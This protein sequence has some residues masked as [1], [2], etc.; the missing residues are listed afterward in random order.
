MKP[1]Q[2]TEPL[3]TGDRVS[4]HLR[5]G[6]AA[7]GVI[8]NAVTSGLW[9]VDYTGHDGKQHTGVIDESGVTRLGEI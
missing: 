3:K 1:K 5:H 2:P 8:T 9:R 7:E 4:F 6:R